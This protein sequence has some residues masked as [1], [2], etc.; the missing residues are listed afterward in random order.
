[1]IASLL[2][3]DEQPN[4]EA[5]T[6]TQT[7]SGSSVKRKWTPTPEAFEKLLVRLAS[8]RNEAGERYE[9]IRLKLLRFFEWRSCDSPD[10]RVD[11]AFNRVMRRIDEGQTIENL[12]AYF[13][14]TARLIFMEW[15]KEKK[16]TAA[17]VENTPATV[18]PIHPDY[19][20]E[21]PRVRCFDSCLE[22]LPGESRKLILA[23]YECEKHEKIVRRKKLAVEMKIPMNA[24]RIR[25]HR[26]RRDLEKCVKNCLGQ[27][28]N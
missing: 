26:I 24:L 11:E 25:A 22:D 4:G 2:P 7:P 20:E 28:A 3:T 19:G 14:E 9:I 21:E 1:L 18:T 10:H 27:Y 8:D 5:E 6:Q 12:M 16:K 13:Y 15:L 17:I 23:Y